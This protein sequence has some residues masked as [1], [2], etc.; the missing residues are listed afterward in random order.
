MRLVLPNAYTEKEAAQALTEAGWSVSERTLRR[1]RERGL[2]VYRMIGGKVRYT[3]TDLL[4]YIER[5]Q[6]CVE[7]PTN[8][9]SSS[10]GIG[11][12][13]KPEQTPSMPTGTTQALGR[14]EGNLCGNLI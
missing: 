13:G 2:I 14:S 6:Q 4:E 11:S 5:G 1:E 3:E 8:R 10:K 12:D 9:D 7:K